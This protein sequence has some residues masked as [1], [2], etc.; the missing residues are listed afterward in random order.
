MNKKVITI[1]AAAHIACAGLL[2]KGCSN[3]T[4]PVGP[5][6]GAALAPVTPV[7]PL[8]SV[9]PGP[10]ST[11]I[12]DEG[13]GTVGDIPAPVADVVTPK[14]TYTVKKGDTLTSIGRQFGIG[15][16]EIVAANHMTSPSALPVGM[17]LVIPGKGGSSAP[18]HIAS[19]DTGAETTAY[20]VAAGDSLARIAKR[21]SLTVSD[22]RSANPAI[23]GDT[24]RIGQTIQLPGKHTVKAPASTPTAPR[25]ITKPVAKV[26][27]GAGNYVV[28]S[29]DTP[30]RIA[31]KNGMTTAEFMALNPGLKARSLQIGQKVVVKGGA[32]APAVPADPAK[33]ADPT[34]PVDTAPAGGGLQPLPLDLATPVAP[35]TPVEPV[36]PA[37]E[38]ATPAVEPMVP[39]VEPGIP[40]SG[41]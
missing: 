35:L 27:A 14:T 11:T 30:E 9:T 41:I 39:A 31:R 33:P 1:V 25:K 34:K 15:S 16:A 3:T 21:H 29:G 40:T 17:T 18:A 23:K 2:F 6:S 37:V 8:P 24:I 38:P 12:V 22:L 36:A 13:T 20:K 26:P 7:A 32:K 10:E 28:V 4:D 5:T 19:A